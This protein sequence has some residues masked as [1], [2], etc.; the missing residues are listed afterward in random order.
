MNLDY[1]D[2]QKSAKDEIRKLL[3]EQCDIAQVRRVLEGTEHG[4][5]H[6][7][8]RK[9]GELGWLSAVVPEAQGGMGLDAVFLCALVE[10]LGRALAPVPVFSSICLAVEAVRLFGSERQ[11]AEVL[12][13][14]GSG[15]AIGA[16]ALWEGPGPLQ[17]KLA[18]EVRDGRLY[19]S[20]SP[21]SD[22][23]VAE[24]AIVAARNSETAEISLYLAHLDQAE[25]RR[26]SLHSLD[27]CRPVARLSFE[28]ARVELLARAVGWGAIE[29][30][31]DRAAVLSAFEQ[32]GGADRALEEAVS[33]AN[34]RHAFGRAI[35]G[36]QA[37]RHR[38]ADVYIQIELAR[39]NAYF[40]AWALSTDS[41]QLP[42][43]ASL[44]RISATRAFELASRE[45]LHV[46]GGFGMTW[47]ADCHLFYRRS[48]QLAVALGG[49]NDWRDRL[50][51][52]L[53][54]KAA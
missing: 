28:G 9:L 42:I 33:Y 50:V 21:V 22:G 41:D 23:G 54:R 14:L 12:P 44:A 53:D 1:T 20:K 8:W 24:L 39:S 7:V 49:I 13:C 19:G 48:R 34:T 45:L 30:L 11:Q 46:H 2:E 40:G 10:E 25:V 43:A 38:L 51:G 26:E 52:R 32:V 15:D 6:A 29:H 35:G 16:F 47:E 17:P 5:H 36:F 4:Y 3:T 27:P 31:L 37:I 18:A